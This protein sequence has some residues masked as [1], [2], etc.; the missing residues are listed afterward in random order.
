[1]QAANRAAT[2]GSRA[3]SARGR[4]S[5]PRPPRRGS[6]NRRSGNTSPI[7]SPETMTEFE[8]MV[9]HDKIAKKNLIWFNKQPYGA[10]A[11]VKWIN[12]IIPGQNTKIVP[13][14]RR[15][16]TENEIQSIRR[17]AGAQQS[18]VSPR[19]SRTPSNGRRVRLPT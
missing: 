12:T 8:D 19:P 9:T 6:P 14:S 15:P 1:M 13:H 11:L 16:F 2:R 10:K 4:R 7:R 18:R 17:K 5:P 3:Q